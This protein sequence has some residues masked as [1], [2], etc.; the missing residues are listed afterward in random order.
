MSLISTQ[1]QRSILV[2][3]FWILQSSVACRKLAVVKWSRWVDCGLSCLPPCL[4]LYLSIPMSRL[5]VR[6]DLTTR[7]QPPWHTNL[8]MGTTWDTFPTWTCLGW[9]RTWQRHL[10]QHCRPLWMILPQNLAWSSGWKLPPSC[11]QRGVY[12]GSSPR[13]KHSP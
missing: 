1:L 4:S 10:R 13:F 12:P 3:A 7:V 5:R 9:K 6:T 11:H 2:R 8:L